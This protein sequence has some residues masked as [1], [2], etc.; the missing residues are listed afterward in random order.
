MLA[1]KKALIIFNPVA[2]VEEAGNYIAEISDQLC[3]Q[4]YR[5]EVLATQK[6]NQAY[7]CTSLYGDEFTLII[8][9]GG[10][11]TLS[12]VI[13]GM[14]EN[15]TRGELG[16][17]PSGSVN[18]FARG[19]DFDSKSQT[20]ILRIATAG[21]ARSFD[22]GL[23]NNH[24]F[25]YVAAFGV[26]TSV[27]YRTPQEQKNTFGRLAYV[28][29]GLKDLSN[30]E[31]RHLK[32]TTDNKSFEDT[33][34]LGLISNSNSIAG[35]YGING[36]TNY[37]DGLFEVTL[38]KSKEGLLGFAESMKDFILKKKTSPL[39]QTFRSSYLK[40]E[41]QTE[42]DWTLDGE[43]GGSYK[44]GEIQNK[45]KSIDIRIDL[46]KESEEII[47]QLEENS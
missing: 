33:Y 32:I 13:S 23:L 5:V 9:I 47:E 29:E 21:K 14:M 25:F 28:A 38:I 6:E 39:V 4:S 46:D 18:D 10:D 24:V 43:F 35:I 40:V 34:V 8:A 42:I 16:I 36:E 41:S 27:S 3:K 12:E 30:I 1:M 11:G 26:F 37:D 17:I 31:E 7:E 44:V 22:T 19:L 45:Q 2:G 15:E 20:E